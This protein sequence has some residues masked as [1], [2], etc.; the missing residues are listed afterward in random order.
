MANKKTK[1]TK[2]PKIFHVHAVV[3]G[4]FLL[5][6]IALSTIYGPEFLLADMRA[7]FQAVADEFVQVSARVLGPPQKPV[8]SANAVCLDGNLSVNLVWADDENSEY[9]DIDRNSLPLVTGIYENQYA[10][11]AVMVG[12]TY[13]YVV[14]ARGWMNPG[15]AVSDPILVTTPAECEIVLP[16]P[17]VRLISIESGE[18]DGNGNWS[19]EKRQPIFSGNSN[20]ANAIISITILG[21]TNYG[22]LLTAN[23]NGYWSWR[24][25]SELSYGEH[26]FYA[27]ATDPEDPSRVAN[28]S[29][30]FN[31][32]KEIEKEKSHKKEKK[33][34]DFLQSSKKYKEESSAE[35]CKE[36]PK[37]KQ[38]LPLQ[39][40]LIA[41]PASIMQGQSTKIT[42]SLESLDDNF[43]GR[44]A[45]V[46]YSL[47]DELGKNIKQDYETITLSKDASY[48]HVMFLE[49]KII[50][51]KYFLRSELIFS[52]YD[53]ERKIDLEILDLPVVHLGGGLIITYQ[54][55]LSDLGTISFWLILA[56]L[57]WLGILSREYWLSTHALR[58]ITEK[59][60]ENLGMVPMRKKR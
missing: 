18:I 37:E 55:L 6:Y 32:E 21:D 27:S 3:T 25:P 56:L 19:T 42:I 26:I 30:L 45:I 29:A 8:V 36:I 23:A 51:G 41:K 12:N 49:K 15:F 57:F 47:I 2:F 38:M 54:Q 17:F 58:Q 31:I 20:I 35:T 9:Y 43:V 11:E 34:G 46:R 16:E 53:I 59:S 10:D 24:P 13:E 14:T 60:L 22:T 44:E 52:D 7:K 4:L 5:A 1:G 50:T 39:Y 48:E 40:S 28:I 33:E